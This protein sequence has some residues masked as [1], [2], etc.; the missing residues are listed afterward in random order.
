M[1]LAPLDFAFDYLTRSG[2]VDKERLRRIAPGF[3]ARYEAER[4][5][6]TS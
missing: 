5:V 3:M 4:N 2:R 6:N 1:A